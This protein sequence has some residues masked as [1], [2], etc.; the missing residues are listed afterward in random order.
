MASTFP[1]IP[2]LSVADLPPEPPLYALPTGGIP[3]PKIGSAPLPQVLPGVS[4]T[5]AV[6]IGVFTLVMIVAMMGKGR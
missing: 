3:V 4:N 5:T 1:V 2:D 6:I